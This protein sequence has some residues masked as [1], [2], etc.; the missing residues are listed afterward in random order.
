MFTN[1]KEK[2]RKQMMKN[3]VMTGAVHTKKGNLVDKN[4]V[5]QK[6]DCYINVYIDDG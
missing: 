5:A 6:C 2:R 1:K 3:A 4:T